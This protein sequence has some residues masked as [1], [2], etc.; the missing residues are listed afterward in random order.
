MSFGAPESLT[1]TL[2]II[3]AW[4]STIAFAILFKRIF[5]GSTLRRFVR[6]KFATRVRVSVVGFLVG[7]QV[8]IITIVVILLTYADDGSELAMSFP[9]TGLLLVAFLND[10]IRGPLGEELGWRG[11]ALNELQ[12]RHAPLKSA[13]VVGVLWGFW[14]TPIWVASGYTGLD[15]VAYILLFLIGIVSF[16]VRSTLFYNLNRNLIVPIIAH[17]LF[18]FLLVLVAGDQLHVLSYVMPIYCLVALAAIV[19]NPGEALYRKRL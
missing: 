16:S 18:N 14:H 12:S 15:L 13:L 7:V 5:P 9:G 6:E 1:T 3:S 11:Y 4:S 19:I 2:Q 8:A 17:Q 10:L